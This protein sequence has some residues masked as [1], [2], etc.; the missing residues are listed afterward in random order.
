[1]CSNHFWVNIDCAY[2]FRKVKFSQHQ[3]ILLS[4]QKKQSDYSLEHL[5]K[6]ETKNS[7]RVLRWLQKPREPH[8]LPYLN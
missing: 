8:K 2:A 5:N 1:M 7:E 6:R 4:E 3:S